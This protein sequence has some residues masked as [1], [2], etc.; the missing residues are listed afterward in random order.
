MATSCRDTLYAGRPRRTSFGASARLRG[1]G[2]YINNAPVHGH[3]GPT[4][5]DNAPPPPLL[6]PLQAAEGII[7]APRNVLSSSTPD[8]D[9]DGSVEGDEGGAGVFPGVDLRRNRLVFVPR[10]GVSSVSYGSLIDFRRGGAPPPITL[11]S[12][13][14]SPTA[15]DP[16]PS[17]PPPLPDE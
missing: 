10:V 13:D 3:S 15:V 4:C 6:L 8:T 14:V 11:A 5:C 17:P 7:A 9:D 12:E 2:L 16:S 1:Q